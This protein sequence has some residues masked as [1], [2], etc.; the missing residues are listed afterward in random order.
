[1][2]KLFK[3]AAIFVIVVFTWVFVGYAFLSL[4]NWGFV[5]SEWGHGSH[6]VMYLI[7]VAG[8]IT[9]CAMAVEKT[10]Q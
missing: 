6:V 4:M 5:T 7:M 3:A 10:E 9:G 8:I 2:K 1:M